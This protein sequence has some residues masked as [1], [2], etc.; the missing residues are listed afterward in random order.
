MRQMRRAGGGGGTREAL[1]S[2]SGRYG[3]E[4]RAGHYRGEGRKINK[5][6]KTAKKIVN[7]TT[8]QSS[9]SG[10]KKDRKRPGLHAGRKSARE[11]FGTRR[12]Q[13]RHVPVLVHSGIDIADKWK[14]SSGG[15]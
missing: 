9:E 8:L 4:G 13:Q 3:V 14:R 7:V 15:N 12:G 1:C 5:Q 2:G 11:L 10:F 6:K